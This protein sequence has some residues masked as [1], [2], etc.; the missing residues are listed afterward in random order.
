VSC[1][2]GSSENGAPQSTSQ[3]GQDNTA[4][5][6]AGETQDPRLSV[7]DD[8]PALDFGGKNFT[9]IYPTWSMYNDYYFASEEI[10]EKMNDAVYKRTQDINERFNVNINPVTKG[11][12]ETIY[13]E[14]SKAVKAGSDDYQMALTHCMSGVPDLTSGGYVQDWN[15]IPIVDFTKPWWNQTMNQTMSVDGILL[16]AVSDFIIFDPNVIYFNKGMAKDLDIGDLYQMVR[17]G[18]WTWDKLTELAKTASK[19]LNGDGKFDKDDQYG[20][21]THIGWMLESAMQSCDIF[22]S[23]IGDSG[24]PEDNLNTERFGNLINT[25]YN[26]LYVGNQ[27]FIGDWDANNPAVQFEAQVPMSS[28]RTL[29]ITDP[30]SAG[31]RYRAYDVEFG[32]LPYPKYDEAQQDYLSLSWNGFMMIPRTAD[33]EFVGAISEALAAESYKY[34]V[35]AYYD[36]LLTSKVARDVESTEM[37]DII[38]KGAVYDFAMDFGNWN[39]LTFPIENILKTNKTPDYVSFLEKNEGSFNKQMQ[40]V[41]D[42]I[43][44]NYEQ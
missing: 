28:G 31:K 4:P 43:R 2:G 36:V 17:D 41:Y 26:L 7:A 15:K 19:D 32:I 34:T 30:L 10:G 5:T 44:K 29:F 20:L 8:I 25:L 24:Y 12:I 35:P 13:P 33:P 9:I 42:G 1:A 3:N 14:V 40:K 23:K 22:V 27:T 11:Y 39:A 18:K 16:A 37:I 21:V 6:S 38:Y